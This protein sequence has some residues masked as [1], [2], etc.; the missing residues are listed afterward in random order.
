MAADRFGGT[1]GFAAR[2]RD[3]LTDNGLATK[4]AL[5]ADWF[6]VA[7]FLSGPD[8]SLLALRRFGQL[9]VDVQRRESA[10]GDRSVS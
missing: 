9:A 6:A 5:S 2:P 3:T 4:H 8:C 10:I 7:N 1:E